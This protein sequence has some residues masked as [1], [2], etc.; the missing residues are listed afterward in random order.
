MWMGD[1]GS[2]EVLTGWLSRSAVL[3]F[4]IRFLGTLAF[5]LAPWP[6]L[7]RLEASA[8]DAAGNAML[9][10][11][12][13]PG[14][15]AVH[16]DWAPADLGPGRANAVWHSIAR[17]QNITSGAATRFALNMRS[18]IHLPTSVFVSLAI[19][20][21]LWRRPHGIRALAVGTTIHCAFLGLSI[22]LPIV[23]FLGDVR[24]QAINLQPGVSSYL[25]AAFEAWVVPPAMGYAVPGFIWLCMMLI[26]ERDKNSRTASAARTPSI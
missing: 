20:S 21:L 5:C 11:Y 10:S 14:G 25:D 24:I 6:G 1:D 2:G 19:A 23:K 8:F 15:I 3:P 12:T 4:V 18:L 16:F 7:G 13:F 9:S 26:S 22:T 17:V